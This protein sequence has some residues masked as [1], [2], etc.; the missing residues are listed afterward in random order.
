[1]KTITITDSNGTKHNFSPRYVV[2]YY[3][4]PA[5]DDLI[6]VTILFSED[7]GIHPKIF[8]KVCTKV[9]TVEVLSGI[10]QAIESI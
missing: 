8:T 10:K 6:V 9:E 4:M 3:T 2:D 7:S 1:M 5:K